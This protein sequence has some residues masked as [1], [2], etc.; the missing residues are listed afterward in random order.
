M[1]RFSRTKAQKSKEK[2]D[3]GEICSIIKTLSSRTGKDLCEYLW[4]T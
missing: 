3:M 4:I 2:P 1:K